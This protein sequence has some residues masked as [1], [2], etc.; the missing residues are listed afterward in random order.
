MKLAE[1]YNVPEKTIKAMV[2]DGWLSCSVHQ[3]EEVYFHYKENKS[4]GKM[5]AIR[6]ASDN[7][8]Y[9]ESMVYYIVSK[10]E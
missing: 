3:Y 1:K 5:N 10:F 6:I 2:K 8:G 7:T 4:L 9:S